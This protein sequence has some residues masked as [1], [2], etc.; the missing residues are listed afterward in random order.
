MMKGVSKLGSSKRRLTRWAALILL[1][2]G[3][4]FGVAESVAADSPY[5]APA[6]GHRAKHVGHHRHRPHGSHKRRGRRGAKHRVYEHHVY[7][8]E[9]EQAPEY[10]EPYTSTE[11]APSNTNVTVAIGDGTP[12]V[13]SGTVGAVVGAALGGLLGSNV[14]NGNGKLAAT[15]AG[16]LA[17]WVIGGKVAGT[18]QREDVSSGSP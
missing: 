10:V 3:L 8:H 18:G 14:G 11:L 6:H 9:V 4:T 7:H 16:T 15:A 5:W 1:P 13:G 2:I 17:G 12:G